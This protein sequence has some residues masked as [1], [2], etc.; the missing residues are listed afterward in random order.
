MIAIE[1]GTLI[2][3]DGKT[4]IPLGALMI[5]DHLIHEI[6]PAGEIISRDLAIKE[7]INGT[8]TYILPGIINNHAHG[9]TFGPLFA[10]GAE[11]LSREQIK[12]NLSRHLLEGTTTVINMDGFALEEEVNMARKLTPIKIELTTVNTPLNLQAALMADGSGL[13]EIH[14]TNSCDIMVKAGATVI[15]EIGAGATLGGMGQDYLYIPKAIRELTG[16]QLSPI[17]AKGLKEAVLGRYIDSNSFD[18]R[19]L[20]KILEITELNKKMTIEEVREIV[21]KCVMPS[22]QVALDGIFEAVRIA[23]DYGLPIIVHNAASSKKVILDICKNFGR[24]TTIILA[25]SNHSTFEIDEALDHARKTRDLGGVIDITSGDFYGSGRL[26]QSPNIT[27]AL[28]EASLVDLMSTDYMGGFHDPILL[29]LE[30]ALEAKIADVPKAISLATGNV[31]K[32]FPESAQ[33]RGI[34]EKGK[35]ADVVVTDDTHISRVDTVIIN[36]KIV[37]RNGKNCEQ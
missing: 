4:V 32:F 30:K 35:V 23:S 10:S 6:I 31:A 28:L 17:E 8:N 12:K 29:V 1:G 15:G 26:F 7:R 19:K 25:H 5:K 22:F 27:F 9:V 36:G 37:V 33:H 14:K 13:S 11:P 2:T 24:E 18:R 3:G 34:L 16:Q 21:I 20:T